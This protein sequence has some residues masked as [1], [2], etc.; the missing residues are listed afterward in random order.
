MLQKSF[1]GLDH[2]LSVRCN[3]VIGGNGHDSLD[4]ARFA[5]T[6]QAKI[7]FCAKNTLD[8]WRS[9]GNRYRTRTKPLAMVTRLYADQDIDLTWK[10]L[11]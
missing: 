5:V 3:M 7:V 6:A 8:Q 2:L 4:D 11:R 9:D 1:L 10:W